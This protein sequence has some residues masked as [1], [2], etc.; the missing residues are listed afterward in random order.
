LL[1]QSKLI[2]DQLDDPAV[3]FAVDN[4]LA[5]RALRHDAY[6]EALEHFQAAERHVADASVNDALIL[7]LNRGNLRLQRLEL[8]AARRDLN[9]C[10]ALA[11][12]VDTEASGSRVKSSEFMARHNLGYL[13]FLAGN[14]RSP[15][16]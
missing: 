14:C 10:V 6:Q 5:L 9:R 15:C 7:Y 12:A 2:A 13:E 4:S 16:S 11:V 8:A 1:A 3:A